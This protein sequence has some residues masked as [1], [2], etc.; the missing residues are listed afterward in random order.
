MNCH[1]SNTLDFIL[2]ATAYGSSPG[3]WHLIAVISEEAEAPGALLRWCEWFV[4]SAPEP[5][6]LDFVNGEEN[7]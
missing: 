6:R 7:Q 5:G 1:F 2:D 4:S 3:I